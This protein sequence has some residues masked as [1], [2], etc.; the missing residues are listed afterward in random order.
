MA[1][2]LT[3]TIAAILRLLVELVAPATPPDGHVAVA[4]L[5]EVA[6]GAPIELSVTIL[7]SPLSGMP[8]ELWL[9]SKD[10]ALADNRFDARDV[11]DPQATQPRM[12][13]K[14]VAPQQPGRYAIFGRLSYVSCGEQRC[15]A[16]RADVSWQLEVTAPPVAS[17]P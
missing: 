9:W 6:P 11:V 4:S 7:D 3:V 5:P 8:V 17:A 13:A 12:R 16:R 14:L 10:I 15:R 1:A 2:R